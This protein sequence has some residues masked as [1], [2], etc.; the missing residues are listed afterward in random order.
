MEP[1]TYAELPLE[2]WC[3]I[4]RWYMANEDNNIMFIQDVNRLFYDVTMDHQFERL[5]LRDLNVGGAFELQRLWYVCVYDQWRISAHDLR[6]LSMF[7]RDSWLTKCLKELWLLTWVLA[8]ILTEGCYRAEHLLLSL[9][10]NH[11]DGTTHI[12][13]LSSMVASM[14]AEPLIVC[15]LD[16]MGRAENLREVVMDV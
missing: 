9:L 3:N 4:L 11:R 8:Q 14:L 12:I 2:I 6:V 7:L 15:I 13:S 10:Q 16:V 1:A 5:D